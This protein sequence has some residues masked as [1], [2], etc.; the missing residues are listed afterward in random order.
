MK[1]VITLRFATREDNALVLWQGDYNTGHYFALAIQRGRLEFTFNLGSGRAVIRS[2]KNV[3]RGREHEVVITREDNRGSLQ[4][5]GGKVIK[6]FAQGSG[7]K[8]I[9][10][11]SPVF[12]GGAPLNSTSL[13]PAKLYK[14]GFKGCILKMRVENKK[15]R[16]DDS[17]LGGFGA[18]IDFTDNRLLKDWANSVRCMDKCFV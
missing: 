6:G 11:R 2:R 9:L 4:L 10:R 16:E 18:D 15:V 3:N 12:L 17:G 7:R 14:T 8:L 1:T 13:P 5:D